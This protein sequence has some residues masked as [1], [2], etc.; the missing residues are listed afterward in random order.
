M[1]FRQ[2]KCSGRVEQPY[3]DCAVEATLEPNQIADMWTN[4]YRY[5]VDFGQRS[6]L[7][8]DTLRQRSNNFVE[9]TKSGSPPVLAFDFEMIADGRHFVP[10]VN[11]A[12]VSIVPPAGVTIDSKRRP[13]III[14]PRAGHGPGIGGF[15]DDSPVRVA[16]AAGH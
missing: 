6:I 11:Y 16:L 1:K 7:F 10:A 4:W 3:Q 9:R 14:D 12:L 8:W 15:K 2:E 13:Y 5:G